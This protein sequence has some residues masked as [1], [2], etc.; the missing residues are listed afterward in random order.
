[1][2]TRPL[3]DIVALLARIGLGVIFI[4]HGWQKIQV[5]ITAT[6]KSFD[7]MG[8]PM[9]TAA[10]I[11]ATFAELLGGLALIVG[12]ALPVAGI[13]LFLD[14]V[15]AVLFVHLENGLFI[16]DQGEVR[17][18]FELALALGLASLLLAAAGGGRFS[19]D[20]QLHSQRSAKRERREAEEDGWPPEEDTEAPWPPPAESPSPVS[21]QPL[22]VTAHDEPAKPKQGRS[23]G[24]SSKQAAAAETA[25]PPP[26]SSSSSASSPERTEA[27]SPRLAA[28]IISDPGRDAGDVRVAGRRRPR[29]GDA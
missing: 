27:G 28:D 4:A 8:V 13:A 24:K 29:G 1:M 20:H 22:P 11:Y 18:G 19:L 6:A 26:S 21:T 3:F 2:R 9:P 5:G 10:A 7:S 12:V 14:M 25:P 23:R 15:G 16:V 17:N